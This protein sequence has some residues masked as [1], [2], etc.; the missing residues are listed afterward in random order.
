M[1][2]PRPDYFSSVNPATGE[3]FARYPVA[4]TALI[5]RTL[6]RG[7]TAQRGW[8]AMPVE[9]R[10]EIFRAF[11]DRLEDERDGLATLAAREMGKPVSEGH[12]EIS[13]CALLLR[14]YAAE[15]AAMLATSVMALDDGEVRIMYQPL[16]TIFSVTPWNF[17]FWQILRAAIPAMMVGNGVLNKPAPNVIGCAEGI[18]ALG[19]ASGL[20]EG[21][22]QSINTDN[23]QSAAIIRDA[24]I[25]GVALT[26]SERAGAS[27]A[28]TGGSALKK[29]VLE[30]GGSDPFI[31]LA[32][33]DIERAAQAAARSR[34]ANAGQV[35]VASKRLIVEA[36]VRD[37]FVDAFRHATRAYTPA[38]PELR[39][40]LLGPMARGDLRTQ[41]AEQKDAS[42]R[43][44]ASVIE[45][46][47]MQSGAGF[48]FEPSILLSDQTDLRALR[49]ETFGPL[50]MIAPVS[51]SAAAIALAN[52]TPF[53]LSANIW[54]ADEERALTLAE[55]I[56]AGAV[57]INAT[58]A[59][60]PRFPFGGI[61]RSGYGR[62][63]GREGMLEF[64][65]IKTVRIAR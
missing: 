48:F 49:E 39:D 7:A 33:A 22:L 3:A 24:R 17:P 18:I 59:S 44:G 27:V 35:C 56:E 57:F 34:F 2:A 54:T 43:A 41:L 11:A 25:A 58:T 30:L 31:V 42:V 61:K 55:Q 1:T 15:G 12:A 65:N 47:G 10:G 45:E 23:Q 53:G 50:A 26:G 32:D 28:A 29:S 4:D 37:D 20:P 51:D 62:E 38:S 36:R 9:E 6:A 46:G 19:E 5:E 52:D 64:T 63:L 40:T 8:A 13:K 16:G 21:V 60:D 14:H